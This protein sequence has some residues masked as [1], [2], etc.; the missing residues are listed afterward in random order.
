MLTE[1]FESPQRIQELRDGPYGRLLEGFADQMCHAGY[2]EIT[3]RRHIRAA[4]HLMYWTSRTGRTI[5]ALDEHLIEEFVGHLNRCR[6]PRYGHMHRRDLQRGARLFLGHA[7]GAGIWTK[8]LSEETV[9]EPPALLT[10]FGR[11]MRQQRG[12]CDATLYNYGLRV[13]DLLNTVGDNPSRFDAHNLRQFIL[14]TSQRCGW[15]AAKTCTT[16][17]RM[18]LR[19]LIAD[20]K[21]AAGLEASIPALAHWRLSSLPRY[22]HSDDVERVSYLVRSRHRRWPARSRSSTV[23]CTPGTSRRRHRAASAGRYRLE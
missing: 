21:C 4:E 22:L 18:F 11:W 10:A 12:T 1:F 14:D 6:C 7:R 2:A 5:G 17:I 3:A 20:G 23:A 15:A 13:R 8:R 9:A 19:F 16:A